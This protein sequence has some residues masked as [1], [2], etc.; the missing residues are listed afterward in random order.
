MLA[1][2]TERR[3]RSRF[4]S[5][6]VGFR[7][8]LYERIGPLD[9]RFKL[10]MFEDSDYALR[11]R[12]AGYRT[13]CAEDVFVH[14]FGGTSFGQLF[15]KG[16][17]MRVYETNRRRFEQKWGAQWQP[18]RRRE[19]RAYRELSRRIRE[20]AGEV[21]R[22]EATVAVVSRGDDHLLRF[23]TQRGWH[24]PRAESGAHAGVYPADSSE[25]IAHLEALRAGGADYLLF[26]ATGFWWLDYYE[27]FRR[28]LEDNY[29]ITLRSDDSCIVFA[30][31]PEWSA[32]S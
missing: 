16:E 15:Q 11:C 5:F 8:D 20:E 28:H 19:T 13:V 7:R 17:H 22:P 30:L 4:R 2:T 32:C 9:E 6:C 14:H 21:L 1:A 3:A 29:R 25:A 31:Q 18:H 26:P 23:A 12:R 27:G 10:G 24:F